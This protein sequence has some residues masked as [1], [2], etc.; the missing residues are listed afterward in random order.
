MFFLLITMGILTIIAGIT[1]AQS[2]HS[3]TSLL[4]II[5]GSIFALLCVIQIAMKSRTVFRHLTGRK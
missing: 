2:W 3:E 5:V 1:E 4:H